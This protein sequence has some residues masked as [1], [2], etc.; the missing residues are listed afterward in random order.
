MLTST[1]TEFVMR[2]S[3]D[4]GVQLTET[5]PVPWSSVRELEGE[6]WLYMGEVF[7]DYDI[8]VA[9]YDWFFLRRFALPEPVVTLGP[10]T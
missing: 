1:A 5:T 2:A 9:H 3:D 6:D 4:D 10:E 8:C 7:T